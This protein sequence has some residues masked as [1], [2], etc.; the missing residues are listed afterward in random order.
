VANDFRKDPSS[1]KAF[2]GHCY[3]QKAGILEASSEDCKLGSLGREIDV[4]ILKL[5]VDVTKWS[6]SE[7]LQVKNEVMLGEDS[8]GTQLHLWQLANVSNHTTAMCLFNANRQHLNGYDASYND[9]SIY[10]RKA[11]Q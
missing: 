1:V 11:R 8:E 3:D 6:K 10:D 5:K 2:T 9:Y 7:I 4:R